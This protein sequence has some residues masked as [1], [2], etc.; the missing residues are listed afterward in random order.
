MGREREDRPSLEQL[1]ESE[2]LGVEILHPGGLEITRELA[3]LC[4]I[5]KGANVLDVASGTGES[6]CYVTEQFECQMVGIDVSEYMIHRARQKAQERHLSME[7]KQ[8]DAHHL[9]FDD[10][11]FDA[12]ISECT[13]CLLNKDRAIGEMVR[14]TRPGGYVGMHDVCWKEGTPERLKQALVEKE[15]ERPETLQGWKSLFE[16]AK[17][18][19]IRTVDKSE[20]I[21]A[22]IEGIKKRLG[23]IGQVKIFLK[24]IKKWGIDG[25][26]SIRESEQIF[27][28]EHTGYGI[29]VGR[30]P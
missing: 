13:M 3:E 23:V 18:T 10:H 22:W 28:S 14:V 12:V 26:K 25:Y 27:Q 19:D 20:L 15:G 9:P 8:G 16:K 2:N 6:A 29:I 30:K 4:H 1:V 24:V 11:A 21:P 17:L 7:F 5:G